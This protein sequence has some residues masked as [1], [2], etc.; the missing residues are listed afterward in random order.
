MS[1]TRNHATSEH[2]SSRENAM[3]GRGQ[4]NNNAPAVL[5][6]V[7]VVSPGKGL[8]TCGAGDFSG[9]VIRDR[10]RRSGY[11]VETEW[12]EVVGR[13][14]SYRDG[15]ARLARHHGFVADPVEVEFETDDLWGAR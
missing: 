15:A 9:T 4:V 13:A 5:V 2:V 12:G 3:A 10:E 8:V 6:A 7:D 1:T 14:G 11:L